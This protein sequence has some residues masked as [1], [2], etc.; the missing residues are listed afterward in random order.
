LAEGLIRRNYSN[1]N[2]EL[3]LGGNFART[4]KAIWTV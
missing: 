4:L 3:I 2:I 1:T